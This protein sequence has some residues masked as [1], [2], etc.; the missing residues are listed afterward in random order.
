MCDSPIPLMAFSPFIVPDSPDQVKDAYD[1]NEANSKDVIMSN[2]TTEQTKKKRKKKKKK[3]RLAEET[4]QVDINGP[5]KEN[6]SVD[7]EQ[8]P[9]NK[10]V[11]VAAS[12]AP[13]ENKSNTKSSCA[14]ITWSKDDEIVIL[15]GLISFQ[16]DEREYKS[17]EFY[18]Y[19]KSRLSQGDLNQVRD[20]VKSLKRKY[21]GMQNQTF[22]ETFQKGRYQE[23]KVFNLSKIYWG[24]F[25]A[26]DDD[27]LNKEKEETILV[28]VADDEEE[29]NEEEEEKEEETIKVKV[30]DDEKMIDDDDQ[31]K[32]KISGFL[33]RGLRDHFQIEH[34]DHRWAEEQDL[35]DLENKWKAYKI[36]EAESNLA[37]AHFRKAL[38]CCTLKAYRIF[39]YQNNS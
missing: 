32:P 28:Q 15:G 34:F 30:A 21:M 23:M 12:P 13:E 14:G 16:G 8:D 38:N 29:E 26:A 7:E 31:S 5:E 36:A 4:K 17:K 24:K 11:K 35:E 2:K 37:E 3:A 18:E 9:K 6:Q 25:D 22:L 27:K 1:M 20:K 10:R 19:I 39:G 33:R